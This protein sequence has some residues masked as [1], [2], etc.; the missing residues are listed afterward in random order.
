MPTEKP[1]SGDKKTESGKAKLD[2]RG[3]PL[4]Q[5]PPKQ[6][7][8][9]AKKSVRLGCVAFLGLSLVACPKGDEATEAPAKEEAKVEE[10]AE[11]KKAETKA[12]EKTEEKA[13][14]KADDKK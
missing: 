11:E 5:K 1:D 12:E 4:T 9:G 13:E 6:D 2:S 3:L 8:S 14:E 7:S 10:K